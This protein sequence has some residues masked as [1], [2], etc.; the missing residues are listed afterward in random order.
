MKTAGKPKI[1][2]ALGGGSIRGFAHIGVLEAFDKTI[3]LE[4]LRAIHLNDSRNPCG[5]HK[6]RHEK[7]G[8]GYIGFDALV[9]VTRHKALCHL[10]FFLETPQSDNDGYAREIAML[11]DAP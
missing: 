10:P 8:E 2:L 1:G 11:R 9:S 7:I 6:D 4:H 3:G 5:A